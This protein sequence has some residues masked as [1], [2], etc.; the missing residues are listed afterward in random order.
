MDTDRVMAEGGG[1]CAMCKSVRRLE[2]KIAELEDE[3]W[4]NLLDKM[5]PLERLG[6]LIDEAGLTVRLSMQG[7]SH[8]NIDRMRCYWCGVT[9]PNDAPE[10]SCT[11]PPNQ[12][13]APHVR[14]SP[15][16]NPLGGESRGR[17]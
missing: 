8:D 12:V 1:Q 17:R 4:E 6:T 11:C 9:W 16:R 7:I 5:G 13:T 14:M 10:L 3:L 2:E 15:K